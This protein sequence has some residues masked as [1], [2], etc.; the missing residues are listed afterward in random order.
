MDGVTAACISA[1]CAPRSAAAVE[2]L[3]A[4][5]AKVN[6]KNKTGSTPLRLAA[7]TTGRS[8]AGSP[9]AKAE[10]AEIVA[11]LERHGARL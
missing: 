7:L 1:A 9:E 5:G 6:A 11:I 2:A 10:Q 8:G 4:A 3:L